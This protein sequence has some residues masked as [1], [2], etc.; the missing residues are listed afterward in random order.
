MI[1]ALD[2]LEKSKPILLQRFKDAEEERLRL[3]QRSREIEEAKRREEEARAM[4]A[5]ATKSQEEARR[6]RLQEMQKLDLENTYKIKQDLL[7]KRSNEDIKIPVMQPAQY[8]PPPMPPK[9]ASYPTT[10]NISVPEYPAANP[11]IMPPPKAP[12]PT[13]IQPRVQCT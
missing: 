11:I 12:T 2:A 10:A 3:E 9:Q 13:T 1:T 7:A 4:A 5:R 6:I 8:S